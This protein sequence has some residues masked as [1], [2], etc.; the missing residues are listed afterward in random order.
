MNFLPASHRLR[1]CFQDSFRYLATPGVRTMHTQYHKREGT[2]ATIL[3][4]PRA[5]EHCHFAAVLVPLF[6]AS[7]LR[8]MCLPT[9]FP[10]DLI[11][12]ILSIPLLCQYNVLIPAC[13]EQLE[14][15]TIKSPL[16]LEL[17]L[18]PH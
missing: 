16:R 9:H 5:T 12:N 18:P 1:V 15:V 13:S 7:F 4:M 3:Q 8:P 6:E 10:E 2:V 17:A 11:E 14:T